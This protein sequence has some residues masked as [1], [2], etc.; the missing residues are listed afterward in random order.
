[1]ADTLCASEELELVHVEYQSEASGRILRIYIDKPG[2]VGIDDC[3]RISRQ[4]GD[5][6]DVYIENEAS[7][8]LEVSSP[9]SERPLGRESDFEKYSGQMVR[10]K[11]KDPLGGKKK[12]YGKLL[13]IQ[14]GI[15][16]LQIN[17][18]VVRISHKDIS[19]ARLVN[20]DGENEC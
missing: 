3:S 4:M 13:G 12:F 5:L 9:G 15:V 7:Y 10:I 20:N 2:G 18:Q 8:N 17:D 19:Q 14:E 1:M 11:T 6:L 16:S